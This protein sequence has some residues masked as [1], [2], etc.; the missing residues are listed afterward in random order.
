[1]NDKLLRILPPHHTF[2]CAKQEKISDEIPT[3]AKKIPASDHSV[4]D[5][6]PKKIIVVSTGV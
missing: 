1:M 5:R 3:T 4:A 2:T 6:K